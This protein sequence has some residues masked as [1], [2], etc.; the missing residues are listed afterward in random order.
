MENQ[1][2][3]SYAFLSNGIAQT[4]VN[5]KSE[6]IRWRFTSYGPGTKLP[7]RLLRCHLE[8]FGT[9]AVGIGDSWS[10]KGAAMKSLAEAW[11][12]LCM[13]V[14]KRDESDSDAWYASGRT[15][16]EAMAKARNDLV[17]RK[18]LIESW[19]HQQGWFPYS[20]E[21]FVATEM[22]SSL[23]RRGWSVNVHALKSQDHEIVLAGRAIHRQYGTAFNTQYLSSTQDEVKLLR[24]LI[25]R[26]ASA[27]IYER[28]DD[29]ELPD[30]GRPEDHAI[31]YQYPANARAFYF[32][33]NC[34]K[35]P[36]SLPNKQEISVEMICDR[37]EMPPVARARHQDWGSLSWGRQSIRERN[38]WP[39]PL[40]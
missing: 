20:L 34:V 22:V 33:D 4:S 15:V 3:P 27:E 5:G 11:E 29:W 36:I 12:R 37:G 24:T 30:E 2:N 39:H 6:E 8:G 13:H 21:D 25:R 40:A 38:L 26:I 10:F 7:I 17:E 19:Q 18:L 23:D 32:V 31:F 16:G 14:Y 35:T 1:W 9:S 28:Q